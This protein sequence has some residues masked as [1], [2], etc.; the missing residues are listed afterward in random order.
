MQSKILTADRPGYGGGGGLF[1]VLLDVL[2]FFG[3][4]G[5]GGGLGEDGDFPW[6]GNLVG[7]L[8]GKERIDV[9]TSTARSEPENNC[10]TLKSCIATKK[11]LKSSQW[12]YQINEFIIAE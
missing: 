4:Y 12:G 8:G 6:V 10:W 5:G 7:G 1:G 2:L 9:G 11:K 3:L